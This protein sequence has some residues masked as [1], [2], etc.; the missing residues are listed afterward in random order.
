MNQFI[1]TDLGVILGFEDKLPQSLMREIAEQV[2]EWVEGK[3]K[4]LVLPLANWE[5]VDKR[6]AA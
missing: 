2:R 6:T 3:A 1:F 4:V 5:I